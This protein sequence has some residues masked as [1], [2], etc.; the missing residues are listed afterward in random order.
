MREDI[1]TLIVKARK[2]KNVSQKELSEKTGISQSTLSK[3]EN[4]KAVVTVDALS[5]IAH[6]LGIAI[7]D[8]LKNKVS[9]EMAKDS[10]NIY[11]DKNLVYDYGNESPK[12]DEILSHL[13]DANML[14]RLL[15]PNL[16]TMERNAVRSMID[17]C[18]ESINNH[19][20]TQNQ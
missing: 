1:E 3:Y 8:I 15:R 9:A 2:L 16:S 12:V 17:L 18:Y 4:G 11:F 7:E 6:A 5:R 20:D 14:I 19:D 10:K 13:T